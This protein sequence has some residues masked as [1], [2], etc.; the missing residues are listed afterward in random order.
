MQTRSGIRP[1]W[2]RQGSQ[3]RF[4]G[5][6]CGAG[7]K[8]INGVSSIE[9]RLGMSLEKKVEDLELEIKGL[10]DKIESIE[11]QLE[12]ILEKLE[13]HEERLNEL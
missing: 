1:P 8:F 11:E 12:E 4:R 10:M 9:N 6:G 7:I 13:E 5:P 3:N 2:R